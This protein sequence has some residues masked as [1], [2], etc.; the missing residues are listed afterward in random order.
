VNKK[1]D[2]LSLDVASARFYEEIWIGDSSGG[3]QVVYGVLSV[4]LVLSCC[5]RFHE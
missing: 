2:T 1:S 3:I 5:G 4:V